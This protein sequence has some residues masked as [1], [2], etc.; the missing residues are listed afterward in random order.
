MNTHRTLPAPLDYLL[1]AAGLAAIW[2][3]F[4]PARL[5][6]Q[7]S[8]VMVNGI[9]MLPKYHRS[10]LVIVRK[11]PTYQIGDVVA[12]HD[13]VMEA[14]VIHRIIAVD[15]RRYVLQGDNNAWIDSYR[16]TAEEIIGRQWLHLPRLGSAIAWMR[17][18]LNMALVSGLL[19]VMFMSTSLTTT[20][21][22]P[23]RSQPGKRKPPL[24]PAGWFETAL[25]IL[26]AAALLS[27]GLALFAFIKPLQRPAGDI[28]YEQHGAFS[29][30]AAGSPGV[31][32]T[33]QVR[34]GEPI[35]IKLACTLNL[36]F[37]YA[38]QAPQPEQVTGAWQFTA[39]VVDPSS[40]WGR[41]LPLTQPAAFS[42]PAFTGQAR[43]DLCQ[44][45][46]LV[47]EVEAQTGFRSNAY[48]LL[49]TAGV[50]ATGSI[51]GQPFD[52]T[53]APQLTFRFDR[54]HFFLAEESAGKDPLQTM[55]P[56]AIQHPG[57]IAN[58][59]QLFGKQ[60][61]IEALRIAAALGLL[62]SL[63]GL[64]VLAMIYYTTSKHSRA[65]AIRMRYSGMLIEVQHPPANGQL[66]VIEL[67]AIEDLARLAE[68]SGALIMH[69]RQGPLHIYQVQC[70]GAIYR[71]ACKRLP[72]RRPA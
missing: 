69:H 31:Y 65:G 54:L 33:G 39:R 53:F 45:I 66:P 41:S 15:Q 63:D 23:N 51:A 37:D 70:D 24:S 34:S 6:G 10:D 13:A 55:Q 20:S 28:A 12:Y 16:P 27:L 25:Y 40:G 7:V 8:Y 44:V 72:A 29:Y 38:L 62:F 48:T 56:G 46:A 9:S 35:F 32:D 50:T 26:L 58:S 21:P 30:S 4:A 57:M 3:L 19:S 22:S 61:T 14:D 42:G 71:C 68:R 59:V 43:L 60:P 17:L 52:E 36:G 5:G 18:P 1:L 11:S 49:V 67:C 2:L 64:L 47:D